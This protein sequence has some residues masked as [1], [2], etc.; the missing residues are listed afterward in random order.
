MQTKHGVNAR[1]PPWKFN[2]ATN[3]NTKWW[4]QR[5]D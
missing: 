5:Q 2:Q 4:Q 3:I 1:S